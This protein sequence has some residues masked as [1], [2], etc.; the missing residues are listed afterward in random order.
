MIMS[1]IASIIL[2]KQWF[3]CLVRLDRPLVAT[4][5]QLTSLPIAAYELNSGRN[6]HP[7]PPVYAVLTD[8]RDFFFLKFDGSRFAVN[9]ITVS[10]KSRLSFIED[11]MEGTLLFLASCGEIFNYIFSDTQLQ[12]DF[13]LYYFMPLFRPWQQ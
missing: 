9:E 10:T 12:N 1:T 7:Q 5:L 2:L 8:L 3:R 11:M 13:S 6:F 4:S